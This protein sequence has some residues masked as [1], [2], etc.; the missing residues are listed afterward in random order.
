LS[1][2]D[3]PDILSVTGPDQPILNPSIGSFNFP[4][5]LWRKS[6]DYL[7]PTIKV[8]KYKPPLFAAY[9]KK[10]TE[11]SLPVETTLLAFSGPN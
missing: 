8:G 7:Y 9:F 5:S 1:F 6:I 4:L 11:I 2:F 3:I 10:E